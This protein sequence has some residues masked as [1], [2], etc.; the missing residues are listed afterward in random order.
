MTLLFRGF[1]RLSDAHRAVTTP[2]FPSDQGWCSHPF[3]EGLHFV[4]GII[5]TGRT[6][7]TRPGRLRVP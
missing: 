7:C 4:D 2:L 1:R 3:G 5:C 6:P